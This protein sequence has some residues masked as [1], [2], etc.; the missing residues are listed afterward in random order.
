M[1]SNEI[2]MTALNL[3]TVEI[4]HPAETKGIVKACYSESVS[5]LAHSYSITILLNTIRYGQFVFCIRNPKFLQMQ[6][7]LLCSGVRL[8]VHARLRADRDAIFVHSLRDGTMSLGK[9]APVTD[10]LIKEL[11]VVETVSLSLLANP[12]L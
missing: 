3:Q 6:L 5:N 1:S 2:V 11:I 10:L 7:L 4:R 9:E 12:Q 8:P